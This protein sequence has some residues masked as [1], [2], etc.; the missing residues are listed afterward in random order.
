[1]PVRRLHIVSSMGDVRERK[2]WSGTPFGIW[3]AISR[4]HPD[5]LTHDI[6][7]NWRTLGLI[8][9]AN[10]VMGL[11]AYNP[12]RVGIGNALSRARAQRVVDSAGQTADFLHFGSGHLP[13]RPSPGQRHYLFTDSAACL[14]TA[15]PHYVEVTNEKHRDACNESD[16]KMVSMLDGI[17]TT[18]DYVAQTFTNTYALPPGKAVAVKSGLG[19]ILPDP[20]AKDYA[21]GYMLFVAKQNFINKGGRL[22][23]DAF[24]IVR[25]ERP[26]AR[27]VVIGNEADPRQAEDLPRMKN[28]PGITFYNWDTPEYRDL[29]AGAALYA[30]PAPDEPWGIIYLESL[31]VRTPILG[32]ERN[33]FPQFVA[34]GKHGFTA[35]EATPE[36]VA[37]TILD[38]LS[39]PER[40]ERMGA[41]GR[42]HVLA[43]YDWDRVA[44]RILK[45][46]ERKAD[47]A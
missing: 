27:L 37:T 13:I 43:E 21:N 46:F 44:E 10:A 8:G 6:S 20:G 30:G 9:K 4:L 16:R 38:A 34:G 11:T 39:D 28:T 26:D 19:R 35:P 7:F 25:R 1:V 15:N 17:F 5:T 42:A 32:L 14:E 22:L 29:V 36:A 33:A 3:Q 2:S 12:G 24:E 41:A 23:L 40:L 45:S 18:A 47:A 31:S